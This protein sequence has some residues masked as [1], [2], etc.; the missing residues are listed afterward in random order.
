M[1]AGGCLAESL[2]RSLEGSWEYPQMTWERPGSLK[3]K[4]TKPQAHP[5]PV[6]TPRAMRPTWSVLVA[7]V[8]WQGEQLL[9]S[10]TRGSWARGWA[11]AF[12]PPPIKSR[13]L[14]TTLMFGAKEKKRKYL[15]AK[16]GA[17]KM[18]KIICAPPQE[19]LT[20]GV[21]RE[22][23]ESLGGE[24]SAPGRPWLN[25]VASAP[26]KHLAPSLV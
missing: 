17:R 2:T 19:L 16:R 10:A 24:A 11:S 4:H 26:L 21:P 25:P 23:G 22:L 14:P 12:P 13:I 9:P 7:P 20:A 8:I 18:E 5:R 6:C 15:E 1:E 3:V